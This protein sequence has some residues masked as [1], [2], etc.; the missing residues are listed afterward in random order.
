MNA[1]LSV[2]RATETMLARRAF[3]SRSPFVNK[4]V[5]HGSRKWLITELD[6]LTSIFVRRRDYKCVTC[7]AV[8]GLQCSHFYSCRYLTIRFDLR[9]CNLMCGTCNKRHNY[10]PL[11]YLTYMLSKYGPDIV[12][13]LQAQRM[14]SHKVTEEELR[15][16]LEQYRSM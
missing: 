14:S 13:E 11:P 4:L 8:Q 9:N 16:R 2:R 1:P 6:K 5:V 3:L 12:E 15:R 7:G 10:E